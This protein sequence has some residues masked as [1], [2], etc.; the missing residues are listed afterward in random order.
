M[1]LNTH[2]CLKSK[3]SC[4]KAVGVDLVPLDKKTIQ[5]VEEAKKDIKEGNVFTL[6]EL[7]AELGFE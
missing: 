3:R 2:N 1:T 4:S 6:E 5:R 7:K